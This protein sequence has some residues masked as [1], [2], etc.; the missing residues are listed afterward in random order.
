[1]MVR[2]IRAIAKEKY[3]STVKRPRNSTH[4]GL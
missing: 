4:E 3:V 2:T 1:M